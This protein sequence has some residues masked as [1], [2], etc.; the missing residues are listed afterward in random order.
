MKV[1]KNLYITKE[2]DNLINE[3]IKDNDTNYSFEVNK[4]LQNNIEIN[5]I[6]DKLNNLSKEIM[7]IRK[8]LVK[9]YNL[10]KQLY[11]DLQIEN[12]Q[13]VRTSQSLLKVLENNTLEK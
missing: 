9:V 1:R 4:L 7:Q 10:E 6:Y 11:A 13:D 8:L 12:I 2:V 3:I 5:K